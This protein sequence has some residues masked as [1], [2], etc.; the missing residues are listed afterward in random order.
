[1]IC[2]SR[3]E[4]KAQAFPSCTSLVWVLLAVI[5][6]LDLAY[7]QTDSHGGGMTH[8]ADTT[9]DVQVDQWDKDERHGQ[10]V[11]VLLSAFYSN[12]RELTPRSTPWS[13][14]ATSTSNYILPLHNNAWRGPVD[15][16][17]QDVA[18]LGRDNDI[19]RVKR[20]WRWGLV[21]LGSVTWRCLTAVWAALMGKFLRTPK[22]TL[23]GYPY[24]LIPVFI[25]G[26]KNKSARHSG[27]VTAT[28]QMLVS[29][30]RLA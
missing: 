1:M 8:G 27:L 10:T 23:Q 5:F 30:I 11:V 19:V 17:L 28:R 22:Q 4:L 6:M 29:D 9:P 25:Q 21:M 13:H 26:E 24:R 18:K 3:F 15:R 12:S 14:M 7:C 16:G 2:R 20:H